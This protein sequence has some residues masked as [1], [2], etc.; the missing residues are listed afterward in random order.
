M[1]ITKSNLLSKDEDLTSLIFKRIC[2]RVS[3]GPKRKAPNILCSG[4][5]LER[6]GQAGAGL[7]LLLWDSSGKGPPPPGVLSC[8]ITSSTCHGCYNTSPSPGTFHSL[9]LP[10]LARW[11]WSAPLAVRTRL[12]QVLALLARRLLRWLFNPP[13]VPSSWLLLL[14]NVMKKAM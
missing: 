7:R 8:P 11:G 5:K 12:Q 9:G 3:Q 4:A 6:W 13:A 1:W 10:D 2:Y 14:G